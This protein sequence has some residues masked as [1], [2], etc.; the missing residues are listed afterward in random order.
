MAHS[1]ASTGSRTANN[2]QPL[3]SKNG[4]L[5][6]L[7][8]IYGLA[9]LA[10]PI[11][12]KIAPG[13]IPL[14]YRPLLVHERGMTRTL[15]EHC[16]ESLTL[17]TLHTVSNDRWYSRR[18]LLVTAEGRPMQM[19]AVRVN[20]RAFGRRVR[21]Q[22]LR[23]ETPLGRVLDQ[24]SVAYRSKPTAYLAIT[25]NSEMMGVFW[26]SGP[27]ALYGRKTD[28]TLD[29]KKVGDLVEILAPDLP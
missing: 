18:I 14:P 10:K 29:G 13:S 12:K 3:G 24:G 7:D 26:M 8:F 16:G 2:R 11:A 1:I 6:P 20:M 25:P 23:N 9:G 27:Q 17:R 28:L 21:A 5:Y 19:G 4:I 15:E 22:I